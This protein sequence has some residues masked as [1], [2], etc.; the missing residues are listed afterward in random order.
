MDHVTQGRSD[1]PGRSLW[2][3][4]HGESTWNALGLVQGQTDEACL[5]HRGAVQARR[6]ARSLGSRQVRALYSSDLRRAVQTAAPL[7]AALGLDPVEDARLRERSF[8]EVEGEPSVQLD[9]G[10]SGLDAG[11]V[12]DPDAA[13]RG[14]ESV[15]QLCR[16]VGSFLDG[17]SA[18]DRL[19]DGPGDVVLVA[20][21]GVVRAALAHLDG[22]PPEH[23]DWGAVG[24]G[25]AVCRP[26]AR[27]ARPRPDRAAAPAAR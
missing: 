7:A 15:R 21:G 26:L 1:G 17:L 23:M 11:R 14:G 9:P 16:R 8:G 6:V 18:D 3:V 13:P 27:A 5:T 2:L 24:N 20:H 19:W 25:T 22:I 10:R 4:R 12:A